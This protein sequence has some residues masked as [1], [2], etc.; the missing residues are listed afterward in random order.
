[1]SEIQ[2]IIDQ[3]LRE[4]ITK[5]FMKA[6]EEDIAVPSDWKGFRGIT[7][8]LDEL[9]RPWEWK[10]VTEFTPELFNRMWESFS[11]GEKVRYV[12]TLI[13]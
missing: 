11:H 5:E 9:S 2:R 13:S 12:L 8:F 7:P 4:E 1:M 6:F 3:M 10:P